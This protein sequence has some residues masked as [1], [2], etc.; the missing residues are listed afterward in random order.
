M[1]EEAQAILIRNTGE[2][3][4]EEIYFTSFVVQ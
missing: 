2:P 1:R 3:G 4:V